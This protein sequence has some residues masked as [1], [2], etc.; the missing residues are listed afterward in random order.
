MHVSGISRI[1]VPCSPLHDHAIAVVRRPAK[2][3]SRVPTELRGKHVD[4]S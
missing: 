3:T 2:H 4:T 1:A